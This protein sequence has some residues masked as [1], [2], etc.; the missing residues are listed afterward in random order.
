[1]SLL[2]LNIDH[3]GM[4]LGITNKQPVIVPDGK[5]Q[6]E[7]IVSSGKYFQQHRYNLQPAYVANCIRDSSGLQSVSFEQQP[8]HIIGN[9]CNL[10]CMFSCEKCDAVPYLHNGISFTHRDKS[11]IFTEY[12]ELY[13]V[14]C[15]MSMT[16][17][18][19]KGL[20]KDCLDDI[21]DIQSIQGKRVVI[22]TKDEIY[23]SS[24]LDG[25]GKTGIWTTDNVTDE[26]YIEFYD[27]AGATGK[28]SISSSIG[29]NKRLVVT[30]D[31]LYFLGSKGGVVTNQCNDDEL[32]PFALRV[33]KDFEGIRHKDHATVNSDKVG[34]Y[35][36]KSNAGLGIIEAN[37]FTPTLDELDAELERD[38]AVYFKIKDCGE[39]CYEEVCSP[40][41]KGLLETSNIT[42][43]VLTSY[44]TEES[45][46]EEEDF[47]KEMLDDWDDPLYYEQG[48]HE[49][50]HYKIITTTKYLIVSHNSGTKIGDCCDSCVC[51]NRMY[52]YDRR[53]GSAT[54]LH[55]NHKDA[56]M[57]NGDLYINSDG[58]I[59]KMVLKYDKDM[60]SFVF[61]KGMQLHRNDKWTQLTELNISGRFPD[62]EETN[63]FNKPIFAVMTDESGFH[64]HDS[65]SLYH[66]TP[67]A[68]RFGDIIR[69]KSLD[70][71]VP[72]MGYLSSIKLD[73]H[74]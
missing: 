29:H 64:Y 32:Y 70:F 41:E 13:I 6:G 4:S 58:A 21:V 42:H 56:F 34:N 36:V 15:D 48:G 3:T 52:L 8:T 1:M 45:I 22:M 63:C 28:F 19:L 47:E 43:S 53:L 65:M 50:S 51:Y 9:A 30:A 24:L 71:I 60:P 68:K 35:Y 2:E 38:I 20:D 11:F 25:T 62:C 37:Q 46:T 33:I 5:F 14:N 40:C 54:V 72:F 44:T 16:Y 27:L 39:I 66:S 61:Y 67:H 73:Y 59:K 17:V 7:S 57:A 74:K 31:L 49:S 18:E 10:E 55:I 26:P 69:G 23:Y 12:N